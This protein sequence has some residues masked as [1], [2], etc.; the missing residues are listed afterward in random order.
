MSRLTVVPII[1]FALL[2]ALATA[3]AAR[4]EDKSAE[5][6]LK[7]VNA[8]ELPKLDA[9]TRANAAAMAKFRTE[10]LEAQTKKAGLIGDL[11][12]KDPKNDALTKLMP[13]RWNA[14]GLAGKL[15]EMKKEVDEVA[16]QSDNLTL[17]SDASFFK[18]VI[19]LRSGDT[20]NALKGTDAFVKVAP[21]DDRGARLLYTIGSQLEDAKKQIE[22]Y[23]RIAHDY[24]D[25][26]SAKMVEGSRKRL[27]SI[28]KPFDLEFTDAV[29]GTEVSMKSL[30]GK[31]VV[32]DFWAT[33]CGP[34]V[35]EM[36]NMKKLYAEFKDKGVEFVGVSLDAP[37][38]EG[39]LDNLKK[40]VAD[41]EITWPQYYQGDGWQSK[42]SSAWG[43][44]SIP[45][46]FVIDGN[47]KLHS[48]EAR[49][50]LDQMIPELLKKSKPSASADGRE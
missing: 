46:V 15:D 5:Q 37:K 38:N 3:P 16:A 14:L 4:A 35:A 12:K 18:V 31:V 21:K 25:S 42:F 30:K 24:P 23:K 44:N 1:S 17:K 20:D 2:G 27:E 22:I 47:G 9:A 29:K 11:F 41:N 26:Q 7:D 28:G 32:L 48:V 33:W 13:E 50:K 39:G 45:A 34:C 10:F 43:V 19:A 8:I 49:G 36:P 6:I 40:F